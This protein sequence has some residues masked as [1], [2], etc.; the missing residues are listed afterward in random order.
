VAVRV[1]NGRATLTGL[2]DTWLDREQAAFDAHEA[3]AQHV[4]NNLQ[5]SASKLL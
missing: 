2:V 3:G 4:D 1:E 5:I